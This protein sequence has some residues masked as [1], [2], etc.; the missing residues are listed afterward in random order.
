MTKNNPK[1]ISV[2]LF[3]LFF[4]ISCQIDIISDE[5]QVFNGD[6]GSLPDSPF[7]GTIDLVGEPLI[8]AG[9]HDG[10]IPGGTTNDGT[11]FPWTI[12]GK[13]EKGKI[14]I[15]FPND[16]RSLKSNYEG[17]FT[18]GARFAEIF[19]RSKN[20][21]DLVVALH[22]TNGNGKGRIYIWYA[23]SAFSKFNDGTVVLEQGWNFI[24]VIDDYDQNIIHKT[25]KIS[26]DINDF[27]KEGYRWEFEMWI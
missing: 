3:F 10:Y 2:L 8:P 6:I 9:I 13:I 5:N 16:N 17:M 23:D 14:K 22:K 18:D 7:Y 26:H 11:G 20:N 15:H 19:I 27:L 25:N 4:A 12:Q 24:E 21:Y 1:T